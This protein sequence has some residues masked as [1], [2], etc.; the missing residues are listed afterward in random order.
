M[1]YWL[2]NEIK[3][4]HPTFSEN[5]IK[6]I[7]KSYINVCVDLIRKREIFSMKY[8]GSF[9]ITSKKYLAYKEKYEAKK[10]AQRLREYN[11]LKKAKALYTQRLRLRK[12]NEL[13]RLYGKPEVKLYGKSE[14][15]MRKL[16]P[17]DVGK[18]QKRIDAELRKRKK[19]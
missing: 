17:M 14:A 15:Q 7:L 9:G 12:Y 5:E 4:R 16:I 19:K 2:I 11:N 3:K 10:E 6:I 13:R 8:L 18:M 1:G